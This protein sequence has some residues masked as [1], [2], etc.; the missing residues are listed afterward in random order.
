[1]NKITK[2][3][4]KKVPKKKAQKSISSLRRIT[5]FLPAIL[6]LFTSLG[7]HSLPAMSASKNNAR[8]VL[9]YATSIGSSDLL[10]RTNTERSQAS[11]SS[12]SL[13]GQLQAA[14]QTK[15]ND[16]VARNYWSHNT[17]TGEEPWVFVK[18]AGYAYKTAGENLAYGFE[19]S[20]DTIVGWMNSPPH[21]ENLLNSSFREVGFGF[22]NSADYVNSGEQTVVVAM[23]GSP[24]VNTPIAATK[25]VATVP[26]P[27]PAAPVVLAEAEPV[28]PAPV[29]E[30]IATTE[31]L[32]VSAAA[33]ATPSTEQTGTYIPVASAVQVSRIQVLTG[34]NARWSNTMLVLSVCAV[35]L[36]WILQRGKEVK[37]L[38]R[39]SEHIL[40]HKIHLDLTVVALLVLGYTLIQ[41]SGTIR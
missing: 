25:P 8:D 32:A 9:S 14:A 15:A 1:M 3:P 17:P 4:V 24:I 20:G 21:R 38:L 6:I 41:T 5:R 35:A 2:I 27:P 34:G 18:N 39:S 40:M 22:A 36:L 29:T 7:V 13:N 10:T 11:V 23:Y 28:S 12:L 16:M 31:P 19:T 37:R 30:P 26:T 33:E